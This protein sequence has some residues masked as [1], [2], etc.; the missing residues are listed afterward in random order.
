[1]ISFTWIANMWSCQK[2]ALLKTVIPQNIEIIIIV[3]RHKDNFNK[4]QS[5]THSQHS[6]IK[7]LN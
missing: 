4:F 1:M 7:I 6:K 3:F 5:K 2:L